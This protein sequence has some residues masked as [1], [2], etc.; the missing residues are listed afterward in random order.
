MR[1][2]R[3]CDQILVSFTT[4]GDRGLQEAIVAATQF[5]ASME[6]RLDRN[7]RPWTGLEFSRVRIR[8]DAK[9]VVGYM[10]TFDLLGT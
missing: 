6:H 7:M 9:D 1:V 3:H 10:Y 2:T 8:F 4:E 5:Y